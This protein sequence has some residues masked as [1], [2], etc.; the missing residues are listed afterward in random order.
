M[1]VVESEEFFA[2]IGDPDFALGGFGEVGD[3]G[4]GFLPVGDFD[5][6]SEGGF[7]LGVGFVGDG[8][9]AFS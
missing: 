7:F 3:G 8:G 5:V 6:G 1:G 9:V 2:D 4:S